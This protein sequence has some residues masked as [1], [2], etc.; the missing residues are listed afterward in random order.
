MVTGNNYFGKP[1]KYFTTSKPN[2][3][4]KQSIKPT[5]TTIPLNKGKTDTFTIVDK[6]TGKIIRH[7]SNTISTDLPSIAPPSQQATNEFYASQKT[8]VKQGSKINEKVL[9]KELS[10]QGATQTVSQGFMQQGMVQGANVQ[11]AQQGLQKAISQRTMEEKV[12]IIQSASGSDSYNIEAQ[13]EAIRQ[14]QLKQNLNQNYS[15]NNLNF[16]NTQYTPKPNAADTK[17]MGNY[18]APTGEGAKYLA[19][20]PSQIIEGVGETLITNPMNFGKSIGSEAKQRGGILAVP[21]VFVEKSSAGIIGVGNLIITNPIGTATGML[22]SFLSKPFKFTASTLVSAGAFSGAGSLIGNAYGKVITL[23]KGKGYIPEAKLIVPEVTSGLKNFPTTKTASSALKEFKN[24]PYASATGGKVVYS[25]S[26]FPFT[27]II[28]RKINV[29]S[30]RGLV[31]GVDVPGLYVSLK[32]VSTYFLRLKNGLGKYKLLPTSLKDFLPRQ[33]KI[34]AV[35]Q[36]PTRIPSSFRTSLSKSQS[37]FG[38]EKL[39]LT[40]PKGV[41]GK[42]YVSPALEFGLKNEA[43]AVIQV[44]S[45]LKRV[46]L[47]TTWDKITGFSKY[48]KINGSVVPIYEMEVIG[49][50]VVKGLKSKVNVADYG[51]YSSGLAPKFVISP[52]NVVSSLRVPSYSLSKTVS[53]VSKPS[54]SI[55]SSSIKSSYSPITSSSTIIPSYSPPSYISSK[56]I[57]SGGSRVSSSVVVPSYSPPSIPSSSTPSKVSYKITPNYST[58]IRIN[59]NVPIYS[60]P[61]KPIYKYSRDRFETPKLSKKKLKVGKAFKVSSRVKG[62]E[63]VLALGVPKNI[64]IAIGKSF[65]GGSTA[66]SFKISEVGFTNRQDIGGVNL[67]QYREPKFS[68]RVAREGFTF[69]EKSKFAIDTIGEVK[70]LKAG[71]I[72]TLSI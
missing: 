69:V 57:S 44:G 55:T 66:R 58:P 19:G 10:K 70:G 65:T 49:K 40:E 28:G 9:A 20:I 36:T 12:A 67:F 5:S 18:V 52:S 35:S 3:T 62:K 63:K 30:G 37:Y 1:S 41:P 51:S 38:K 59:Y 56:T 17:K 4:Q 24:T 61:K 29:T 31:K 72:K 22:D 50:G 53:G 32:G 47:N 21:Q 48:T 42:P 14:Q 45:K 27:P 2:S 60:I 6:N 13:K 39:V 33:P 54:Y 7:G 26:D 25:A 23:G 43:E 16:L 8:D 15:S 68:G 34:L 11:L 46:G 64:A 71:K